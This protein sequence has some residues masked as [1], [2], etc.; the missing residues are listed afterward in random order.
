VLLVPTAT[1]NPNNFE[2][3]PHIGPTINLKHFYGYL[4]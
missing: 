3:I 4:F 1:R 2:L